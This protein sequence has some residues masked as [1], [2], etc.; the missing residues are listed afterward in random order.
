ME[1][2][3][4]MFHMCPGFVNCSNFNAATIVL[5]DCTL[6]MGHTGMNWKLTLFHFHQ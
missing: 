6:N 2:D 1:P 4:Q 3:R 5:K